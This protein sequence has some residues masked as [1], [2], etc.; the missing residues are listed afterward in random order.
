MYQL[1]FYATGKW[2]NVDK[3]VLLIM[4]RQFNNGFEQYAYCSCLNIGECHT[5]YEDEMPKL[6]VL[7]T[8]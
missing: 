4:L 7:R 3:T 2:M 1:L 6:F 8:A 5:V